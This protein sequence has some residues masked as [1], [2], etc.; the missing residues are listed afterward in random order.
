MQIRYQPITRSAK[1]D[2]Q[3]SAGGLEVDLRTQDVVQVQDA[4]RAPA[5]AQFVGRGGAMD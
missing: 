4:G 3:N 5:G 2:K 1:V